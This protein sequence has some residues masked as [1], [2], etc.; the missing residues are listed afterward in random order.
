MAFLNHR[1][2][3]TDI[4]AQVEDANVVG[5]DV[6]PL[7]GHLRDLD[8]ITVAVHGQETRCPHVRSHVAEASLRAA[9]QVLDRAEIVLE[10]VALE[11]LCGAENRA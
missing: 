1:A 7:Q 11:A 3:L 9:R 6:L 8:L 2:S 5:G 4:G 10:Q